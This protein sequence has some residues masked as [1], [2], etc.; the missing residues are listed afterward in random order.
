MRIARFSRLVPGSLL[1]LWMALAA[2]VT[3]AAQ[4]NPPLNANEQAF[5]ARAMDDNA[6]QIA[7]AKMALTKS[8]N[9][10]VLELANAIIQQRTALSARIA[11]LL[12]AS[13]Q[14][15]Q[16]VTARN[17]AMEQEPPLNG[18]AF[19]DIF[20][21]TTVRSH[22]RMISAYEAMKLDSTNPALKLFAHEAIPTLRS[23][24][25]IAMTV[26]RASGWAIE[27]QEKMSAPNARSR[28][29]TPGLWAPV[30]LVAAPW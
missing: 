14:H 23:N 25:A 8:A 5:L 13:G 6:R 20:T 21:S 4:P 26:L 9:P 22:C 28:P 29:Q 11:Q 24:L 10:R 18:D 17:V 27:D 16:R 15:A 12:P 19:D 30:L 3:Q 7:M 2:G 1:W